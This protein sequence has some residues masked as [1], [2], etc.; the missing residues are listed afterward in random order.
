MRPSYTIG[1][2]SRRGDIL[3]RRTLGFFLLIIL[4]AINRYPF[5]SEIDR[6]LLLSAARNA[7]H[8]RDEERTISR[9]KRLLNLFPR[10]FE[11]REEFIGILVQLGRYEDAVHQYRLL[12][13][14]KPKDEELR[15]RFAE[16]LISLGRYKEAVKELNLLPKNQKARRR[17]AQILS[18][19]K[20][21]R[22]SIKHYEELLRLFPHDLQLKREYLDVLYWS[23]RYKRFIKEAN[24]FLRSRPGD[25]EILHHLSKSYLI[26]KNYKGAALALQKILHLSPD[27]L[28]SRH[29]LAK[30]LSWLKDYPASIT[31]YKRL[32]SSSPRDLELRKEYLDILYWSKCYNDYIREA[33]SY[34]KLRPDDLKV[35][36]TL[37]EVLSLTGEYDEA[38][39]IYSWLLMKDLENIGLWRSYL[40]NLGKIEDKSEFLRLAPDFLKIHL[41]EVISLLLIDAYISAGQYKEAEEWLRR[42]IKL[43]PDDPELRRRL[44]GILANM[45]RYDEE[46]SIL[47]ELIQSNPTDLSLRFAYARALFNAKRFLDSKEELTSILVQKKTHLE[48][49]LLNAH[50]D[51]LRGHLKGAEEG[52]KAV[53]SEN[54]EEMEAI[55]GLIDTFSKMGEEDKALS[56][57]KEKLSQY[58]KDL[59]LR[60]RYAILLGNKGRFREADQ[61]IQDILSLNPGSLE[62]R[63]SQVELMTLTQRYYQAKDEYERIIKEY[64]HELRASLGLGRVL[65]WLKEYGKVE[66]LYKDLINLR[67]YDLDLRFE[68]AGFLVQTKR[69]VE[70]ER[71]FKKIIDI[72]PEY[73]PARFEYAR[74]LGSE[75]AYTAISRIQGDYNLR[76]ELARRFLGA[77]QYS[78][79]KSMY[80]SLIEENPLSLE[81]QMGYLEAMAGEGEIEKAM[82]GYRAL[83]LKYPNEPSIPIAMA[84]ISQKERVS[85][86]KEAHRLDPKNL[87]TM[88]SLAIS[89]REEGGEED[90][91]EL[92]LEILKEDPENPNAL[93]WA[94]RILNQKGEGERAKGLLKGYLELPPESLNQKIELVRRLGYP[95]RGNTEK[96]YLMAKGLI[97]DL[98]KRNPS[99]PD[100][101]YQFAELLTT[102]GERKEA[103]LHFERVL[104]AYPDSPRP[105]LWKGRVL[106][107]DGYYD[108][109]IQYFNR[110]LSRVPFDH[111]ALREKTRVLGWAGRYGEATMGY[112]RLL[113][114]GWKREVDLEKRAKQAYWNANW[115]NATTLYEELIQIEPSNIEALFELGQCYSRIGLNKEAKLMYEKVLRELPGHTQARGAYEF[116]LIQ[117]NPYIEPAFTYNSKDGFD[118]EWEI[119]RA[120]TSLDLGLPE[121]F[122]TRLSLGYTHSDL[123][124]QHFPSS[125]TEIYRLKLLKRFRGYSISVSYKDLYYTETKKERENFGVRIEG[126]VFD[127]GNIEFG[128]DRED[129]IENINMLRALIYKDRYILKGGFKLGTKTEIGIGGSYGRLSD[130]NEEIH[131]RGFGSYELT[132]Y[133][134]ILKARV[135]HEYLRYL[136]NEGYPY[137]SPSN[138]HNTGLTLS[139][140]HF[141]NPQDYYG[142]KERYYDL[143]YTIGLDNNGRYFDSLSGEILLEITRRIQLSLHLSS[144]RSIDFRW[145]HYLVRFRWIL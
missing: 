39:K 47:R 94:I 73:L 92:F 97:E 29:L 145:D 17:L 69:D 8:L 11:T 136:E 31:H 112:E 63:L 128:F 70:A 6:D 32:I 86:L 115:H 93:V 127:L 18:W 122:K 33:D 91:L 99:D 82:E 109:S 123:S 106:G 2:Y 37:A 3:K 84:R 113:E 116:I 108:E 30:V 13:R 34:L 57:A 19:M 114:M 54:P 81:F 50:I 62:A 74:F 53:L 95:G 126:R 131:L 38:S 28:K 144:S 79:S 77:H 78:I 59:G 52:Y 134:R 40:L 5:G 1:F 23:K 42:L 107:W 49:R 76:W 124:F 129:F 20:D 135:D 67:P 51:L 24:E 25:I 120:D 26:L 125:E 87:R 22:A 118:K 35:R 140:R 104:I 58:P 14:L 143:R 64:P 98:L 41:D 89:L 133:P 16:F 110:Y 105:L 138:Y 61:I 102:Y 83:R 68:Y 111:E 71:E 27:D 96:E 117:D 66:S 88:E 103:L 36:R 60:T 137:F 65:R 4:L 132:R 85:L 45:K 142:A 121:F 48:A 12:I 44:A 130:E 141:L 80:A 56:L 75:E 9:Y 7:W 72:D 119:T 43:K 139:F 100:L 101:N 15:L 90:G 55:L 46:A 21:Y 10:D